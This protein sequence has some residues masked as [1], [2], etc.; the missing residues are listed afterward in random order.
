MST[1]KNSPKLILTGR[2]V[3]SLGH[4]GSEEF[5]ERGP[6]FLTMSNSFK[7]C[8]THFSK[9]SKKF[10]R[11]GLAPLPPE[12]YGPTDRLLID[13]SVNQNNRLFAHV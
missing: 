2:P 12:S 4:Q 11:C 7:V 10:F 13:T 8:P 9:V 6:N 5:S 1:F 3:T